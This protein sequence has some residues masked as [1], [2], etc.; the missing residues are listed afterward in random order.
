LV[1]S[2]FRFS[3]TLK[4]IKRFCDAIDIA[5]QKD[6]VPFQTAEQISIPPPIAPTLRDK[7]VRKTP[8]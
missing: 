4:R 6:D 5:L 2:H 8:T 7:L 3:G 1:F